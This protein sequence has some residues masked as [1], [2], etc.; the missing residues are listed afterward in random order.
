MPT[1]AYLLILMLAGLFAV[2]QDARLRGRQDRA[3][4]NCS[5]ETAFP[6]R[7]GL[8]SYSRSKQKRE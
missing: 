2:E 3:Q 5:M 6:L 1:L 4:R 7:R 8:L